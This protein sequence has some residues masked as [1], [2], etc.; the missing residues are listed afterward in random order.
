MDAPVFADMA[1]SASMSSF[2]FQC[3]DPAVE[4]PPLLDIP[5]AMSDRQI[6]EEVADGAPSRDLPDYMGR[7]FPATCEFWV[8]TSEWTSRYYLPTHEPVVGRVPWEFTQSV[9]KKLLQWTDGFHTRLARGDQ[10]P[11]HGAILQ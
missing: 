2:M 6:D 9:F 4:L 1:P 5:G 8:I 10:I 11:H 3:S 7:T